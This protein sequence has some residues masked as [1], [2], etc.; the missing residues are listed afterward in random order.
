MLVPLLLIPIY[1]A[2][3]GYYVFRF[4]RWRR[5][6]RRERAEKIW[7]VLSRQLLQDIQKEDRE[8]WEAAKEKAPLN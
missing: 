3:V 8:Q 5:A 1:V 2:V 6:V 4:V 7:M